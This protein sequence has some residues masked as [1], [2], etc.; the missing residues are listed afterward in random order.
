MNVP[1]KPGNVPKRARKCPGQDS[2]AHKG[3]GTSVPSHFVSRDIVPLSQ[4]KRFE[5]WLA[6]ASPEQVRAWNEGR[7]P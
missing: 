4:D 3:N 6:M 1:K 7:K 5:I 2:R